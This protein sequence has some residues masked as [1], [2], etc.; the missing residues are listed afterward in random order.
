MAKAK[1]A[2]PTSAGVSEKQL[3]ALW[4]NIPVARFVE[5]LR[6]K[7]P[8]GK[9][10]ASGN[11]VTGRCPYHD[12]NTPSFSILLDRGFGKCFSCD[13]YVGNPV[14]F[15]ARITGLSHASALGDLKQNFSLEGVSDA[16]GHKLAA[17]DRNQ[18]VK[19]R[20]L[21]FAHREMLDAIALPN[22][23]SFA[24][25]QPAVQY[26]LN[27]RKLPVAALPLL[28]MIGVLPP[29]A[30]MVIAL[31]AEA[32]AARAVEEAR[33]AA[34]GEKP[35]FESSL[36]PDVAAYFQGTAGWAGTIVLAQHLGLDSIGRIKLRRPNSREFTMVDEPFDNFNGFFGLNFPLYRPLLNA[37]HASHTPYV[38]E[39]EFD[40]LSIMAQQVLAGTPNF[41][42]LA[43]CGSAGAAIIDDLFDLGFDS[44]NLVGDAP[45]KNGEGL[46]KEWLPKVNVLRAQVYSGHA[47]WGGAGDP[48]EAVQQIG[49]AALE[50]SFLAVNDTDHFKTPARWLIDGVRGE[51]ENT[52]VE[53]QR[54]RLELASNTGRVLRNKNDREDFVTRCVQE[55]GLPAGA[56]RRD[57]SGHLDTQRSYV[58]RTAEELERLFFV[59]GVQREGARTSLKLWHRETKRSLSIALN[60]TNDAVRV[61]SPVTGPT[62]LFFEEQIGIPDS[63]LMAAQGQKNG[64]LLEKETKALQFMLAQALMLLSQNATDCS[65]ARTLGAGI[66]RIDRGTECNIYV[67]NGVDVYHGFYDG[68]LLKWRELEGPSEPGILF[69]VEQPAWSTTIRDVES[70]R[71]ATEVDVKSCLSRLETV[72]STGWGFK[73]HDITVRFLAAHL[74]AASASCAFDRKS[75]VGFHGDTHS[76]KSKLLLGLIA[77]AQDHQ[78][79][80][81]EAAEPFKAFTTAAVR[82]GMN[83]KSLALCIDEFE[84]DGTNAKVAAAVEGIQTSILRGIGSGNNVQKM[85]GRDGKMVAYTHNYFVFLAAIHRAR[86][87]QD[88][89]RVIQVSLDKAE[90]RMSPDVAIASVV[91][92]E[93]LHA[94]RT[95]ITL[96]FLPYIKQ[97]RD[98]F[99][100][101]D[102]E[103]AP[104]KNATVKV[105]DRTKNGLLPALTIMDFLGLDAKQFLVDYATSNNDGLS[106]SS[107]RTDSKD[108]F[109][110]VTQTPAIRQTDG[111]V[112][113]YASFLLLLA[114]PESRSSVNGSGTGLFYDEN[115]KTLVVNW[116]M[117][118]QQVLRNHPRYG[119]NL[120]QQNLR[121]LAGRVPFALKSSELDS[122]GIL[123]RLRKFGLS[124]V[125]SNQLTG[126]NIEHLLQDATEVNG[127]STQ[128]AT[129]IPLPTKPNDSIG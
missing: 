43:A 41:V 78:L 40:A 22:D 110:W 121:E 47:T 102:R 88:A 53:Q 96:G 10:T 19:Q 65:H 87:P 2:N 98:G 127:S 66:H 11:K 34:A 115:T 69:D 46:I 83:E 8:E 70:L 50:K 80:M 13:T 60:D 28:P 24:L 94:L 90:G 17:W 129:V 26:L 103:L 106:A 35:N 86:S 42:V 124:G 123:S 44:V 93:E 89:N 38:V 52:P 72:L 1:T 101:L 108:I 104:L 112:T 116:T 12:D 71:R 75:I 126:Y 9:W 107:S 55:F 37:K 31:D 18:R 54:R 67:V 122:R 114:T 97:L 81:L 64:L 77:G 25:A 27:V 68:E 57:L 58:Y 92:D 85:G 14:F 125:S 5:L 74:L 119:K 29:L 33:A 45:H 59:I 21:A 111:M 73:N 30:K 3:R 15:W 7:N 118:A 82:Q 95:D 79:H 56:L 128:T 49:L 20:I 99:R 39:G 120:S 23:P 63:I 36:G 61:L 109:D 117:A 32:E 113:S 16:T 100:K 4:K 51:I 105:E 76:G 91:S 84:D 62:W 6:I 48:D